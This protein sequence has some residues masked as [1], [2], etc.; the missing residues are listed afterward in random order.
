MNK[1][2]SSYQFTS[3][4]EDDL[5]QALKDIPRALTHTQNVKKRT[6]FAETIAGEYSYNLF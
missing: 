6:F 4:S 3:T 5:D 1:C 2:P